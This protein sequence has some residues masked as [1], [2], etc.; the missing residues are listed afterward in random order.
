METILKELRELRARINEIEAKVD[1]SIK[2]L[3]ALFRSGNLIKIGD[4]DASVKVGEIADLGPGITSLKTHED[5]SV[6]IFRTRFAPWA[7]LP[8]HKHDVSERIRFRSKGSTWYDG[9]DIIEDG[10]VIPPFVLHAISVGPTG[11]EIDVIFYKAGVN[12]PHS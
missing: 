6:S 10:H 7:I 1:F 2:S 9:A 8:P 4:M 12:N 5:E 11:G 3:Q